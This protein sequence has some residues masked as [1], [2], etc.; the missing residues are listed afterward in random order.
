MVDLKLARAER[1]AE[2]MDEALSILD[3]LRQKI[4]SGEVKA[5]VA[6][7]VAPDHETLEWSGFTQ[8]TTRLEIQGA[9]MQ[10]FNHF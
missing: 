2:T 8:K 6:V 5:F 4:E 3:D 7:G 9:I 1:N 10:L